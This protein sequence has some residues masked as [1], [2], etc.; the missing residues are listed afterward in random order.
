MIIRQNEQ[1][2][3]KVFSDAGTSPHGGAFSTTAEARYWIEDSRRAPYPIGH[4][5][6]LDEDIAEEPYVDPDLRAKRERFDG[7][8][9]WAQEEYQSLPS[10][11]NDTL[12]R[13]LLDLVK[14][15]R[16]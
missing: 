13:L 2:R 9:A 4:P 3:W 6:W 16:P 8:L 1:R 10:S 14:E 7:K 15:L 5:A 11:E 12:F